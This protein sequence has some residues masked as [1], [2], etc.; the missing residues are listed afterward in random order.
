MKPILYD[1]TC[2]HAG[3]VDGGWVVEL[4]LSLFVQYSST[5]DVAFGRNPALDQL[6]CLLIQVLCETWYRVNLIEFSGTER[7]PPIKLL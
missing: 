4:A 6:K 2:V 5:S 1:S 7:G 3:S